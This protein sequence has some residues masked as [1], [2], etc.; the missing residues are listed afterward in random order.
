ML[1]RYIFLNAP[2]SL[3]YVVYR[4]FD[5]LKCGEKRMAEAHQVATFVCESEAKDYCS[6]RNEMTEKNGSDDVAL[7][8]R[9]NAE[10]TGRAARRGPGS[11]TG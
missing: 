6:Y 10:L 2:W 1:Y 7:I 9:P 4:H 11:A 8:A 5:E 3:N